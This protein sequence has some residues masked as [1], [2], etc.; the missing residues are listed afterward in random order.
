MKKILILMITG[1]FL[2]SICF[3]ANVYDY[4]R[5]NITVSAEALT[6]ISL[7]TLGRSSAI[8][9]M[10]DGSTNDLY[11]NFDGRATNEAEITAEGYSLLLKP[12]EDHGV[13]I[14]SATG[15]KLKTITGETTVRLQIIL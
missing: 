2:Q 6:H 10:N 5:N 11:V 3:S 7:S 9:V 8:W 14:Y 1:L 4:N 12:G 13:I 15:P